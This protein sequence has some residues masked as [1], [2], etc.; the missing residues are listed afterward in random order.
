M[1]INDQWWKLLGPFGH[2]NY[3]LVTKKAHPFVCKCILWAFH[4]L[5][6]MSIPFEIFKYVTIK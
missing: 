2:H 1:L 6:M 5:S 3:H 4:I